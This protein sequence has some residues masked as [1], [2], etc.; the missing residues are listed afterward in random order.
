MELKGKTVVLGV[1]AGIAA[2]WAVEIVSALRDREA[3][4][5]VV[6]TENAV[7]FITPLTLQTM[8]ENKVLVNMFELSNESEINHIAYAKKADAIIIAP[9]TANIIGKI[10]SGIADDALTTIVMATRAPVIICPSM[11][12][13]MW[14]NTIV[15]ENVE[16][17]K[18]HGYYFVDPTY[19]KMAC[20]GMGIG[21]L[22]DIE[23]IINKITEIGE[24]R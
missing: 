5:H 6:M 4:V 10:T 1:C 14:R 9:A 3:D 21:R 13:K 2:Y 24:H 18:K 8:S 19:G 7:R 23:S 17:L 12:D 16:K 11:N 15:Q 20:G 22:A